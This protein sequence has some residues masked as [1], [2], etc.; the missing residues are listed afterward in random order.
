MPINFRIPKTEHFGAKIVHKACLE[1]LTNSAG[2]VLPA[3][4][5]SD[6]V[7]IINIIR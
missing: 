2:T 3:K 7:V 1:F 4:R 6:A 5:Y